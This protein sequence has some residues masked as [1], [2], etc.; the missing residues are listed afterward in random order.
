MKETTVKPILGVIPARYGSQRFPGKLLASLCGKS[1]LQRTY[2][3]IVDCEE[4]D[5]VIIATDDERIREHAEGFGARVALTPH[6][7]RSGSERLAALISSD[8]SYDS[9]AT[10][11]NIQGD[12][13]CLAPGA[14]ALLLQALEGDAGVVMA[15]LVA[16]LYN[17]EQWLSRSVVKCV[18]DSRGRALYFSRAPLPGSKEG[19]FRPET[20]SYWRHVGLYAYRRDFLLKYGELGDT[21]LQVAEDLEQ[22]KV[23]EHGYAIA[24]AVVDDVTIGVDTPEDLKLLEQFLCTVNTS[25][26]PA[27][28]VPR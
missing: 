18:R 25:L 19:V 12:E 17:K 4:L 13:P 3:N 6:T 2:E 14:V 26:L 16:P 11:V 22:L 1:V 8:S 9:Y 10:V 21:P 28:S 15:T 24:T 23:L 7:C 27:E 5:A 20:A